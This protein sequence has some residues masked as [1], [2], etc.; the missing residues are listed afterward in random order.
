MSSAPEQ[1]VLSETSA[2]GAVDAD[3]HAA[4]SVSIGMPVY[5]GESFI[6]EALDSLLTQT[7]TDFE[8]II[9]DNA[10]TD[11][12]EAICREYAAKDARIRYVRQSGNI[13]VGENFRFV[14]QK[15][16]ANYFMWM[17]DDDFWPQNAIETLFTT[18]TN[19]LANVDLV[20]G[21]CQ[22]INIRRVELEH[23]ANKP[24]KFTGRGWKNFAKFLLTYHGKGH[25]NAVYGL[26]KSKK[27]ANFWL[28]KTIE[29]ESRKYI[30]NGEYDVIGSDLVGIAAVISNYKISCVKSLKH[31]R[32]KWT[33]EEV[34]ASQTE[35]TRTP[36]QIR[37][38]IGTLIITRIFSPITFHVT[39]CRALWPELTKTLKWAVVLTF[40]PAVALGMIHLFS[41]QVATRKSRYLSYVEIK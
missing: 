7:F 12:T 22:Q 20:Y 8:L 36:Q 17:T 5:N 31:Y 14:L 34:A 13:S 40:F 28:E 38:K 26:W 29:F 25:V 11:G 18:L 37:S 4:P 16:R 39:L 32:R 1:S 27:T 33:R 10:S 23:S 9:S 2:S 24:I 35:E 15:S 3:Q 19:S 30:S 6:R 41:S 21:T